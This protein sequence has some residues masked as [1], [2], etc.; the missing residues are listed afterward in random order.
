MVSPILDTVDRIPPF[1]CIAFAQQLNG[2]SVDAIA[3]RSNNSRRTIS[4]LSG[5]TSWEDVKLSM[6][7]QV[8]SACKVDLMNPEI[9]MAKFR[10]L[11]VD[12]R[13]TR[14]SGPQYERVL[15]NFRDMADLK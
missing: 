5:M 3:E 13:W 8:A 12:K 9:S 10:G 2:L 7:I 14:L 6:V 11:P 1:L 4:R 15:N